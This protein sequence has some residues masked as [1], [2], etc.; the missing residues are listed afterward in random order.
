MSRSTAQGSLVPLCLSATLVSMNTFA[1]IDA[2]NLF[3]GG[4]KSLGWKVDYEKLL[5]YLCE[6][7]GVNSA[8]Y[9]GGVEI[10]NYPFDYQI[11]DTVPLLLLEQYLLGILLNKKHPP[12]EA[13]I[14]LLERHI[15][16]LRFYKKLEQFGY[17]L[18]LKPVKRYE[19]EDGETI[20]RKANCDV[21]MTYRIMSEQDNFDRAVVLSGDGDFLPVLRHLRRKKK[22]VLVL[23]RGPRTAREIRQFAGDKFLDF[24]RLQRRIAF[25]QE[26]T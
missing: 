24:T 25:E 19:S 16:R 10:H 4:E 20:Q 3:Y 22:E 12:T 15:K 8:Y 6:K 17:K 2:S 13:G 11:Q 7:Y 26:K 5:G 14:L 23:S 9:F 18:I 1:F 21:E